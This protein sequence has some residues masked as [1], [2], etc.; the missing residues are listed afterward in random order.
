MM[1]GKVS[2]FDCGRIGKLI[3]VFLDGIGMEVD[4]PDNPFAV[5]QMPFLQELLGAP[6]LNRSDGA[7]IRSAV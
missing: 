6:L 7:S 5:T 2:D 3:F 1:W 4:H